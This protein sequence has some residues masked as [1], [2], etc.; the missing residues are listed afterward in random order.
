MIK[1][2]SERMTEKELAEKNDKL[3]GVYKELGFKYTDN[4][5]EDEFADPRPLARQGAN[6]C[7]G[8]QCDICGE[9]AKWL[10]HF[11]P[12]TPAHKLVAEGKIDHADVCNDARCYT[13]LTNVGF[14]S[15]GCGG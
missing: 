15:C 1:R 7:E 6:S 12:T 2:M 9:D 14:V 8:R 4:P 11:Y 3:E 5:W 10:M 13:A